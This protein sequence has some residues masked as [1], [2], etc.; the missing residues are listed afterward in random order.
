MPK[1]LVDEC[2][3]GH[4][5]GAW[6]NHLLFK[7][8]PSKLYLRSQG[9]KMPDDPP[10]NVTVTYRLRGEEKQAQVRM[11]STTWF[12]KL[13]LPTWLKNGFLEPE[14]PDG[15]ARYAIPP[16][17]IQKV[18]WYDP[19]LEDYFVVHGPQGKA[20][21]SLDERLKEWCTRGDL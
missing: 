7:L 13:I 12:I 9:I 10:V 19:V 4:T 16:H 5:L 8:L 17:D 11:G 21:E 20:R 1:I 15:G 14:E 2:P 6:F 3:A 18:E